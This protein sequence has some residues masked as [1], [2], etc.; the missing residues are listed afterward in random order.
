MQYSSVVWQ[1]WSQH[2]YYGAQNESKL[3][4]AEGMCPVPKLRI[5]LLTILPREMQLFLIGYIIIEICEIFTV[6]E[7]PLAGKVRVVSEIVL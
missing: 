1:F 5:T 2:S 4:L 6:G 7:F 3:L